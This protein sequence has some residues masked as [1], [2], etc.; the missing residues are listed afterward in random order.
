MEPILVILIFASTISIAI[1]LAARQNKTPAETRSDIERAA[2]AA[3]RLVLAADQ[4]KKIG[5]LPAA[6]RQA[7][8]FERLQ[9]IYPTIDDDALRTTIESVVGEINEAQG[10][11]PSGYRQL[12]KRVDHRAM[13]K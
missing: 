4:L 9:E 7:W 11:E 8:V 1:Y 6:E 10:R 12:P 13:G 5:S 3:Y 2:G